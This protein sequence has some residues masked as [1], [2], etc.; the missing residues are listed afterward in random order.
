MS[1]T[2]G[3]NF[4]SDN[5]CRKKNNCHEKKTKQY[6]KNKS[7]L[8]NGFVNSTAAVA[9]ATQEFSYSNNST[10]QSN[11]FFQIPNFN[12][13]NYPNNPLTSNLYAPMTSQAMIQSSFSMPVP[14]SN[15]TKLFSN[16]S[17]SYFRPVIPNPRTINMTTSNL[18]K[19]KLEPDNYT[20]ND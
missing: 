8:L 17:N 1:R 3:P 2:F 15:T 16:S 19:R 20:D 9:K 18:I 7:D 10:P 4:Y 11:S 5:L 13:N 6:R 14:G 12:S